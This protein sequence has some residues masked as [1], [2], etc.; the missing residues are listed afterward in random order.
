MLSSSS[1]N[2]VMQFQQRNSELKL[3]LTVFATIRAPLTSKPPKVKLTFSDA[4]QWYCSFCQRFD[5]ISL[6]RWDTPQDFSPPDTSRDQ[7]ERHEITEDQGED[8]EDD[9]GGRMYQSTILKVGWR[10]ALTKLSPTKLPPW[11]ELRK[12]CSYER[13]TWRC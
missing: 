1:T 6:N 8:G 7:G 2:I 9:A 11:Q 4:S 13:A 5:R 10:W 12:N 3:H